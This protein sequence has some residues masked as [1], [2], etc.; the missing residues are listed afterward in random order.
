MVQRFMLILSLNFFNY[1]TKKPKP[2][3]QGNAEFRIKRLTTARHVTVD[4]PVVIDL[5]LR[6]MES[7]CDMST[8]VWPVLLRMDFSRDSPRMWTFDPG[9]FQEKNLSFH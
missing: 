9:G 6:V 7:P 1:L 2:Q 8:G 3:K 5:L 4:S